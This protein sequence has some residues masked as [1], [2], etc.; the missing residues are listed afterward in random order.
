M[1]SALYMYMVL[2]YKIEP[3]TLCFYIFCSILFWE[4][5]I[6]FVYLGTCSVCCITLSFISSLSLIIHLPMKK[7]YIALNSLLLQTALQLR[8]L[9]L[10]PLGCEWEFLWIIHQDC[11]CWIIR[12][13]Y[14]IMLTKVHD[15]SKSYMSSLILVPHWPFNFDQSDRFKMSC[16]N[17]PY[18]NTK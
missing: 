16:C 2:I 4:H 1:Y 17:W 6:L 10:Y 11:G 15:S 8:V 5:P 7:T 18:R 3:T 14:W 9:Y 13:A 12:Y